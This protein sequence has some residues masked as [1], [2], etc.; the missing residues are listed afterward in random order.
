MTVLRRIEDL[1]PSAKL[2]YKVLSYN[3]PLT[4]K[5]IVEKSM[6]SQRTVRDALTR[7]REVDVV[8]EKVYIPDA[9]QNL[10]ELTAVADTDTDTDTDTGS[11]A[12][13]SADGDATADVGVSRTD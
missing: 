10:Y 4:Q 12:E 5:Q 11:E 8:A 1:P 9:R 7:L 2:V 3:G 13:A 6:L